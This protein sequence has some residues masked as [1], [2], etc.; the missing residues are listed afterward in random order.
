MVYLDKKEIIMPKTQLDDLPQIC[1]GI[2]SVRCVCGW[3]TV[4]IVPEEN[5]NMLVK[6]L[7]HIQQ[8]GVVI[9]QFT[10]EML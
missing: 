4:T 3:E 2:Q 1:A 8:H 5:V 6:I 9:P 7:E 10:V